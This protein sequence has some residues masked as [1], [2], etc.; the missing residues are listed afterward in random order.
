MKAAKS[1]QAKTKKLGFAP[2]A[3]TLHS[4]AAATVGLTS[5]CLRQMERRVKNK[6]NHFV[7]ADDLVSDFWIAKMEKPAFDFSHLISRAVAKNKQLGRT[8]VPVVS[9]NSGFDEEGEDRT[10]DLIAPNPEEIAISRQCE[11]LG[12]DIDRLR[13]RIMQARHCGDRRARQIICAAAKQIEDEG[14][15][16]FGF[17]IGLPGQTD[18]NAIELGAPVP[19]AVKK[20]VRNDDVHQTGFDFGSAE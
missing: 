1:A 11:V 20:R 15:G 17:D 6:G 4:R 12:V 5:N 8:V 7:D 3:Q 19:R 14:T 16:F 13:R 10:I 9:L 2:Q 18:P